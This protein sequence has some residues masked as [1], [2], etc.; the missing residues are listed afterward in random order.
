MTYSELSVTR[1][2]KHVAKHTKSRN[3]SI[4]LAAHDDLLPLINII[5]FIFSNTVL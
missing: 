3:F 4:L 1:V 2:T 5:H